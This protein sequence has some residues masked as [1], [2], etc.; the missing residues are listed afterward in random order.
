MFKLASAMTS[1]KAAETA[2]PATL[3]E[4]GQ[5]D[6]GGMAEGE[7]EAGVDR[8]LAVVHQLAD[9]VIDGGDVVGIDGVPQAEDPGEEGG[10]EQCGAIGKGEPGPEPGGEIGGDQQRIEAGGTVECGGRCPCVGL[11]R[12][13]GPLM[14][15]G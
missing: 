11:A 3:R 10:A 1:R 2:V 15:C 8:A 9:D 5:D 4:G 6:H 14:V 13:G 7:K 12:H